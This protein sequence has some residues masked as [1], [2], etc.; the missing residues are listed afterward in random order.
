MI[1][2]VVHSPRWSRGRFLLFSRSIVLFP[3]VW[4]ED[5]AF[6]QTELKTLRNRVCNKILSRI[7]GG[8]RACRPLYTRPLRIAF[9]NVHTF[10]AQ[11]DIFLLLYCQRRKYRRRLEGLRPRS[12]L[13]PFIKLISKRLPS[14]AHKPPACPRFVPER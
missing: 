7:R 3:L 10:L 1:K 13:L 5:Q 11:N 2:G 12:A 4:K 8:R 9:A 14:R 6:A